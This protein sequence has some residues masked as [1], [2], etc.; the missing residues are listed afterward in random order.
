M[1]NFCIVFVLVLI[2]VIVIEPV[3]DA[4]RACV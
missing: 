3:R 1:S 4:L 2:I